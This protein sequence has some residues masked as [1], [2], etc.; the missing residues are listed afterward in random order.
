MGGVL[1][2]GGSILGLGWGSPMVGR[3]AWTSISLGSAEYHA[4]Q[5][6]T[7]G[8]DPAHHAVIALDW[9]A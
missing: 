4:H 1:R 3:P 8:H 5:F 7:V 6:R 9:S 2:L